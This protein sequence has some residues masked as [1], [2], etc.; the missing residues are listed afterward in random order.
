MSLPPIVGHRE[1]RERIRRTV[2]QGRLPQSLLFHG[3]EGVGKERLALWVA[4][5]ILCEEEERPCG[6]CRSCRHVDG[7]TH[8]DAHWFFPLPRPKGVSNHKL[9]EKLEEARFEALGQRREGVSRGGPGDPSAAIYLAAVEEIR[10]RAARRPAMADHAVYVIGD[11]ERMVPQ[12]ASPEAANAFLK[13]LEEPPEDTF[14]LL[15]SSRPAELLPTIRS[16]LMAVRVGALLEEEIAEFLSAW[17]DVPSPGVAEIARRSRGSVGRALSLA[18]ESGSDS[19]ERA[20]R[21]LTAAARGSRAQR[22]RLAVSFGSTGA[23]GRFTSVLE[24]LIEL[25]RDQL[26]VEATSREVA[27]DPEVAGAILP[28]PPPVHALL[29][30]VEHVERARTAASKNVNPQAIVATMLEELAAS[31]QHP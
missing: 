3:P 11:A 31:L 26:G 22:L 12:A 25:L 21:I 18:E 17:T 15:T 24:H 23:R 9:R 2:L 5:L 20:V 30:A 7:L 14:L 19:R 4:S 27:F 16:R 29:R 8:P 10:S 28:A 6:R 13:L 1:L